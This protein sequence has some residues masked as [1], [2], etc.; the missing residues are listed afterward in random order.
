[1]CRDM[2]NDRCVDLLE[3]SFCR[4]WAGINA[5]VSQHPRNRGCF[6]SRAR[7]DSKS[8]SSQ[9]RVW[10]GGGFG[11]AFLRERLSCHTC[12]KQGIGDDDGGLIALRVSRGA[13]PDEI[14]TARHVRNRLFLD[15]ISAVFI[16]ERRK[17]DQIQCAVR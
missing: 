16:D 13:N 7:Q 8:Q 6:L 12:I 3:H 17:W 11:G 4:S 14:A 5:S 15:E 10:F 9:L 2:K 1:M